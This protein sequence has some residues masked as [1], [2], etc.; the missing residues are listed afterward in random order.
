MS[1]PPLCVTILSQDNTKTRFSF[2]AEVDQGERRSQLFF[3]FVGPSCYRLSKG[4]FVPRERLELIDTVSNDSSL[5]G[6]GV[7]ESWIGEGTTSRA[8][9]NFSY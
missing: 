3:L 6:F 8:L 2:R 4:A 7:F 9:F 1:L 5:L